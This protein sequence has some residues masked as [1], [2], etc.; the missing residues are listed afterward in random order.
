MLII[1]VV[2]YQ[3]DNRIPLLDWFRELRG[4]DRKAYAKGV[5]RIHLLSQWGHDLRR[6]LADY[7]EDDIHELRIRKG[8][9][10]YR[11][12]YFFLGSRQRCWPMPS[13]RKVSCRASTCSAR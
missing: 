10:H 5:A 8:Q 1:Q 3:E 13:S 2:F 6:P 9:V 4:K 7:L 12:L 11:I